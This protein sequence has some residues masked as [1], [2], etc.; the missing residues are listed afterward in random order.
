MCREAEDY[1]CVG[2]E[3]IIY[4]LLVFDDRR[5]QENSDMLGGVGHEMRLLRGVSPLTPLFSPYCA[6]L[7][8][9]QHSWRREAIA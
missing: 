8:V 4:L 9:V 2:Y 5:A 3:I 7:F 1:T 6:Y